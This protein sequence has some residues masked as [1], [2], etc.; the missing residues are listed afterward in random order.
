MSHILRQNSMRYSRMLEVSLFA[1]RKA[2]YFWLLVS[3]APGTA[4][5]SLLPINPDHSYPQ[6]RAC[7]LSSISHF[8]PP[9][10]PTCPSTFGGA[11]TLRRPYPF[12]ACSS[13]PCRT[14]PLRSSLFPGCSLALTGTWRAA[15]SDLVGCAAQWVRSSCSTTSFPCLG[16]TLR[17]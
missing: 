9:R 1:N 13:S 10:S 6:P 2:N 16:L 12:S 3:H 5:P 11:G 8:S 17:P 15:A 14:F 7:H 4:L